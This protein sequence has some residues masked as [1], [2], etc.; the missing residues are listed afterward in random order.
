MSDQIGTLPDGTRLG[1]SALAV[2]NLTRTR[3][4]YERVVGVEA[5]EIDEDMVVLG[6]ESTPIIE[7]H[8]DMDS[9]PEAD[10]STGLYHNAVR[11]PTRSALADAFV[12][13]DADWSIEGATDHGT[14]EAIYCSDPEGNG[15]ELYRDL[16]RDRWPIGPNG[17]I[18]F[19][20]RPLDLDTLAREATGD[21]SPPHGCN[22]GHIHLEVSS[23]ERTRQFYETVIG[24]ETMASLPAAIFLAAGGYHHHVG[25]NT[26]NR[27]TPP[28]RQP[29]LRYFEVLL[30]NPQALTAV[31]DRIHRASLESIDRDDAIGVFDPDGTEVRF[32]IEST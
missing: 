8:S 30:P 22:L 13:L 1:R 23:I 24:F 18:E 12:R 10:T 32:R 9:D 21:G 19:A 6:I 25:A 20:S 31:R 17:S 11:F 26:W 29:G 16:P 27:R 15:L 5:L 2:T 4:F 3:D 28:T 7:L 14:S